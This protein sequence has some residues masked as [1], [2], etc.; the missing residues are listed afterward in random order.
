MIERN[1]TEREDRLIGICLA[2][3]AIIVFFIFVASG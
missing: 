1:F 2:A 3:L